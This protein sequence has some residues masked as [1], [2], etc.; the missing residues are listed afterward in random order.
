M[1]HNHIFGCP[2]FVLQHAPAAGSKLPK[3][4]PRARLGLNLGPLPNH[5][6]NFNLVL[7]LL[8]GLVS[9]QFNCRFNDFFETTRC[10][11]PDV[12]TSAQWCFLAGLK[13][14]H[15][16]MIPRS[17]EV[18]GPNCEE[19]LGT[20]TSDNP[21]Q[22]EPNISHDEENEDQSSKSCTGF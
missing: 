9:P 2:V 21:I 5:A 1:K 3:W 16:S 6:R 12:V 17:I 22:F 14:N 8:T 10:S 15:G 7:N 20:I 4:S 19:P 13:R 18:A 11:A